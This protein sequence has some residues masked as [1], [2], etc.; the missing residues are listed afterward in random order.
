MSQRAVHVLQNSASLEDILDTVLDQLWPRRAHQELLLDLGEHKAWTAATRR[1]AIEDAAAWFTQELELPSVVHVGSP[2]DEMEADR[3]VLE[4]AREFGAS[5]VGA[6]HHAG[7]AAWICGVASAVG[8][9]PKTLA[10]S[11]QLPLRSDRSDHRWLRS[12]ARAAMG[13]ARTDAW[14]FHRRSPQTITQ[15]L[16]EVGG[17]CYRDAGCSVVLLSLLALWQRRRP[18]VGS[19]GNRGR[20]QP[21]RTTP[22]PVAALNWQLV[23]LAQIRALFQLAG[24]MPTSEAFT[25]IGML[26]IEAALTAAHLAPHPSRMVASSRRISASGEEWLVAAEDA[27]RSGG[28]R[29]GE[30]D[31]AIFRFRIDRMRAWRDARPQPKVDERLQDHPYV[32][33]SLALENSVAN[34]AAVAPG[35]A[36]TTPGIFMLLPILRSRRLLETE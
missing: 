16:A 34:R 5:V 11:I 13:D 21:R 15:F 2:R 31:S 19:R 30:N 22:K 7:V 14:C 32:A 10:N 33:G 28:V 24:R 25:A 17:D 23:H 26:A 27:L 4:W 8:T 12:I 35:F 20:P 6:E 36:P 9:A 3:R 18:T 29:I 1:A